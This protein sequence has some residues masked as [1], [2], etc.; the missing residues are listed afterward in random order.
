[1][2]VLTSD[3]PNSI[4]YMLYSISSQ[5]MYR[6]KSIYWPES[7][8]AAVGAYKRHVKYDSVFMKLVLWWRLW[9]V[10]Q[11]SVLR[12][13]MTECCCNAISKTY[14]QTN[15]QEYEEINLI[16]PFPVPQSVPSTTSCT[17]TGVWTTVP[18]NSTWMSS[19]RSVYGAMLSA[20][21]VTDRTLTTVSGV[22]ILRPCATKESVWHGVSTTRTTTE[23]PTNAEVRSCLCDQATSC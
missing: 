4:M 21:H 5:D 18:G 23:A 16:F 19:S 13:A 20:L 6:A 17:R 9:K 1:M 15:I 10:L 12:R 22:R 14:T 2:Y 8:S 3:Q 11:S 7:T